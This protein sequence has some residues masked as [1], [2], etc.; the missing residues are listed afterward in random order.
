MLIGLERAILQKLIRDNVNDA[1]RQFKAGQGEQVMSKW[2]PLLMT[3]L[4]SVVTAVTPSVQSLLGAHPVAT[5]IIGGVIGII[6][7][8]L[9][10]PVASSPASAS[11]T[12]TT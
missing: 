10:S 9:P 12:A 11:T 1:I 8:F 4:G 6:L 3:I 7:H 5:S 2:L